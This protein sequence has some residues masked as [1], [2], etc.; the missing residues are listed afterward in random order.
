MPS[1]R[2]ARSTVITV[3][4]RRASSRTSSRV[5][6]QAPAHCH[7][8]PGGGRAAPAT[9]ALGRRLA[10]R[11]R[12]PTGRSWRCPT[13]S[14]GPSPTG[15][16][17]RGPDHLAKGAA[18]GHDPNLGQGL[19]LGLVGLSMASLCGISCGANKR[20]KAALSRS[21]AS[22]QS[23]PPCGNASSGSPNPLAAGHSFAPGIS[24]GFPRSCRRERSRNPI[25]A[26]DGRRSSPELTARLQLLHAGELDVQHRVFGVER[27]VLL[28]GS[29]GD[30]DD[31][32]PAVRP[33]AVL[34][35]PGDVDLAFGASVDQ[36]GHAPPRSRCSHAS[37]SRS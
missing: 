8:S 16:A 2:P 25:A 13:P 9:R 37:G 36:C 33:L 4:S 1:S 19:Y 21:T 15:K 10:G 7:R 22:T 20:S 14:S 26:G 6:R 27:A 32:P 23:T 31:E 24:S 12:A 34:D 17:G 35:L 18:G 5:M 11:C 28:C 3:G 29:A 30:L